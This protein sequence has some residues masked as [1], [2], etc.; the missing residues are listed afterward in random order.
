[1]DRNY[2]FRRKRHSYAA[3]DAPLAASIYI[4]L[5][6]IWISRFYNYDQRYIENSDHFIVFLG[7]ISISDF[8][9]N[10]IEYF[11]FEERADWLLGYILIGKVLN[12]WNFKSNV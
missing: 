6:S 11:K 2:C 8:R 10:L 9:I 12:F 3:C 1:M 4:I 7:R 5:V